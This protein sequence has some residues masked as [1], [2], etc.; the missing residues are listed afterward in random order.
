MGVLLL[1]TL[2]GGLSLTR[3]FEGVEA[4]LGLQEGYE[5]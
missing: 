5:R 1:L 2:Q 3:G 4:G